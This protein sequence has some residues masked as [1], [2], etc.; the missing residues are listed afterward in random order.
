MEK[1]INL[2]SDI[3]EKSKNIL[4]R[5]SS[6]KDKLHLKFEES[7]HI[8]DEQI[9][10]DMQK[11]IEALQDNINQLLEDEKKKSEESCNKQLRALEDNFTHNHDALVEKAFQQIIGV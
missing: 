8:L 10:N 2:L 11:R 6:E 9:L 1:I 3:E 5:A 7:L 4:E